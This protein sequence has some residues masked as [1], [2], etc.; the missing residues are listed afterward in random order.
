MP[1]YIDV[2]TIVYTDINGKSFSVKDAREISNQTLGFTIDVKK[3]NLLDEIASRKQIYGDN[4]ESQAWKIFDINIAELA[5]VD[6]DIDQLK[7]LKI[8]I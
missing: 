2:D 8:P 7:R 4:G 5:E 6:F 1:R 3:G